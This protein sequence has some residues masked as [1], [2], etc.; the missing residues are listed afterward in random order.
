ME[1]FISQ[2]IREVSDINSLYIACLT[3]VFI[4]VKIISVKYILRRVT[5]HKNRVI[6]T[7]LALVLTPIGY[8]ITWILRTDVIFLFYSALASPW[9]DIALVNWYRVIFE[10][11]KALDDI[12]YDNTITNI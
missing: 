6:L 8:T 5:I 2:L 3:S 4:A 10:P 1:Q 12:E 7:M 11:L 9:I